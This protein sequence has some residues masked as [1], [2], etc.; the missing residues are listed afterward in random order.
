ML[1]LNKNLSK[2]MKVLIMTV[3]VISISSFSPGNQDKDPSRGESVDNQA[4][5]GKT[6]PVMT[7]NNTRNM[8]KKAGDMPVYGNWKTFTKKDGLPANKAYCVRIDGD[9]VLVGTSGGLGVYEDGEWKTYSVEDGIAHNGILA[10]DVSE[11]SGD[12]WLGT[13][14]GLTSWSA[15]KFTTYTQLNS[16]LANDVIYSVICD[17][18]DVWSA[19]GGGAG[20]Y[21]TYKD[22]WAIYMERNAPMHEPW[23]YGVC[24]GDDKV[25]IAA[26]GGGV[27][28]YNT[29]TKKFRDFPDPDKQME[30]DVFPDD[31]VVH[32]I[33]TGVSHDDGVLWVA[34]YFGV[35]RYDGAHWNTYFEHD[36]G[37]LSDFNNFCRAV[38]PVIYFCTD[39]GLSTFDGNTWVSYQR[40]ENDTAGKVVITNGP[41]TTEGA[42]KTEFTVPTSI[43]HNFTI[44][45]DA[46]DEEIWVA[47]SY[48]VCH[49]E[50]LNK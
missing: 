48:G 49:G 36:S 37:L 4:K 38:G 22:E 11:L 26:W 42:T 29:K 1:K 20:H 40:N 25:Y 13:L 8:I 27:L 7:G 9:R 35:N 44:G 5:T 23:T 47:T 2:G 24:A 28:E 30:L 15:G 12:V 3:L 46:T 21:D 45:V 41:K 19:T 50:R 10:I 31:G 39:E 18:K 32:D 33:T 43:S 17:G 16:G 34:T 14:G 6:S